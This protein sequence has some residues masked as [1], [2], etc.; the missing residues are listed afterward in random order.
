[1]DEKEEIEDTEE[2]DK[3]EKRKWIKE[4]EKKK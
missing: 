4:R 3:K 1:M 2:M